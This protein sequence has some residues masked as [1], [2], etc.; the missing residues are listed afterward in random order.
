MLINTKK[1]KTVAVGFAF[2]ALHSA[3][4]TTDSIS[5]EFGSGTKT[6]M[7]RLGA[8]WKWNSQWWN[9]NGSHISG[10]WDLS[11]A[12]WRGERFQ[13][14]PNRSQ[15]I[16]AIGITPI[17]RF[18]NNSQKGFYAEIGIGAH[19]LSELYDNNEHQLSTKLQFGDHVG[20]G[21]VFE[22]ELELG[23]KLQ[24]FSN[25]SMKK[26]NDGVNFAIIKLSYPI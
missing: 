10:Y 7:A 6:K 12:R 4:H 19:L 15:N 22:N 24:H 3:G 17:F 1:W 26:P 5:F 11:V 14:I 8:Q 20:I 25:A 13:N 18:Q 9:S 2:A 16:S 23:L 21:Y